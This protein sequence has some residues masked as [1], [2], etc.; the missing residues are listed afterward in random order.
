MFNGNQSELEFQ[1]L[2][3]QCHPHGLCEYSSVPFLKDD[4]HI[5][6]KKKAGECLVQSELDTNIAISNHKGV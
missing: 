6:L 2:V 3:N 4:A 1:L 5:Y